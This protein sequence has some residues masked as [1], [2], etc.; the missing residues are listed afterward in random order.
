MSYY[1][2]MLTG[3]HVYVWVRAFQ[4]A[5]SKAECVAAFFYLAMWIPALWF[6]IHN[7]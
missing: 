5:D 3:F 4:D 6:S 1:L 2:L 7:L